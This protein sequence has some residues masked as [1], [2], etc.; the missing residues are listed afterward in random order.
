[1]RDMERT[2]IRSSGSTFESAIGYSRA[3]RVRPL[4]VVSGTTAAAPDG[5][6]G[7]ADAGE[8]AREA[9]RRIEAA[10]EQAGA[11]LEDVVRTRIFLTDISAFQAVG[12]A[13]AEAFG[14]SRPATSLIEVSAFVDPALLVEIEAD[15]VAAEPSPTRR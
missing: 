15:A 8:Q 9:L 3:V 5:P 1:M 14:N 7:G 4:V 6:V 2:R 12:A 11:R 13:H 10:L